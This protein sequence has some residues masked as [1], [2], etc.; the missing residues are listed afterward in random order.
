MNNK[1]HDKNNDGYSRVPVTI[2]LSKC[3]HEKYWDK[4]DYFQRLKD[5]TRSNL[6]ENLLMEYIKNHKEEFEE[7]PNFTRENSS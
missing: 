1:K 5:S 4:L 6:I 7:I 2:T 3:L